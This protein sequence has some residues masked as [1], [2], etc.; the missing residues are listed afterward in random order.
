M[1]LLELAR[2][3]CAMIVSDNSRLPHIHNNTQYREPDQTKAKIY[4]PSTKTNNTTLLTTPPKNQQNHPVKRKTNETTTIES[5]HQQLSYQTTNTKPFPTGIKNITS[6]FTHILTNDTTTHIIINCE[7]FMFRL[8]INHIQYL[9]KQSIAIA[10]KYLSKMIDIHKNDYTIINHK[11]LSV[12]A[13]KKH[14]QTTKISTH[15]QLPNGQEPSCMKLNQ[16]D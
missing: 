15:Y 16:K 7:S 1:P 8:N 9:T 11:S 2:H 14:L 12:A 5:K 6:V 10:K 13:L 4:Q 3:V